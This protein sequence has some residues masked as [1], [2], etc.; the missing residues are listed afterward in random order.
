M[1]TSINPLPPLNPN[2]VRGLYPEVDTTGNLASTGDVLLS[3]VSGA[4]ANNPQFVGQVT[5]EETHHDDLEIVD[6]PIQQGAPITD[7]VFKKPAELIL[8]I[9]WSG[10]QL[11][12]GGLIPANTP[13]PLYLNQLAAIYNQLLVGQ[14]S[15]VLY[16]VVTAKRQYTQM[17]IKSIVTQSDVAN[18]NVLMVTLHMR[19]LFIVNAQVIS[20]PASQGAQ[21]TPQVTNPVSP[22]G[23]T[24]LV[25]AP[26]L[27]QVA[28]AVWLKPIG[29]R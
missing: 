5:L 8:H 13:G 19:Q 17:A 16:T 7:H 29:T 25:P 4:F 23:R 15:A 1:A 22:N 3:G 14:Q 2:L 9:G 11:V 20:V 6:H 21:A 28:A 12:S 10:A 27:D 26:T 18:E 24:P